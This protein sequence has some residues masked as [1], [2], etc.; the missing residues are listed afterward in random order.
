MNKTSFCIMNDAKRVREKKR[1]ETERVARKRGWDGG[2]DRGS[3]RRK[4]DVRD[5]KKGRGGDGGG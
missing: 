1:E 2:T 3:R 4:T 5:G